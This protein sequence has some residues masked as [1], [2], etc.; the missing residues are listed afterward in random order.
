MQ[1]SIRLPRKALSSSPTPQWPHSSTFSCLS[2]SWNHVNCLSFFLVYFLSQ[3]SSL[4]PTITFIPQTKYPSCCYRPKFQFNRTSQGIIVKLVLSSVVQSWCCYIMNNF[5]VT[6]MELT[7]LFCYALWM[8]NLKPHTNQKPV[9]K[10]PQKSPNL[11][12]TGQNTP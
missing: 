3:Q 2:R 11:T 10:S 1:Y 7:L 12:K 9:T 5:L 4:Q 6:A 8:P